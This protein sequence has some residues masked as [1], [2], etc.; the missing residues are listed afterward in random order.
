MNNF[1]EEARLLVD[2]G[3]GIQLNHP[4][5]MYPAIKRLLDDSE[6]RAR[7][8]KAAANTV[9]ANKGAVKRNYQLIQELLAKR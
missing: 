3:G 1:E 7:R 4:D 8:G 2:T 6:E 9:L 5:E